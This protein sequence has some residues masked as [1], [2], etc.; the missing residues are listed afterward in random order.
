MAASGLNRVNASPQMRGHHGRR[1]SERENPRYGPV[2]RNRRVS[3]RLIVSVTR[4]CC[5]S[6]RFRQELV[7]R[8]PR[9][10]HEFLPAGGRSMNG[11]EVLPSDEN[12][13]ALQPDMSA[14]GPYDRAERAGRDRRRAHEDARPFR[15]THTR[16]GRGPSSSVV[17]DHLGSFGVL[18]GSEGRRP[19]S[20]VAERELLSTR[21]VRR[22]R[23]AHHGDGE[24]LRLRQSP[25]G[26]P[27]QSA[28][29]TA[30]S[31]GVQVTGRIKPD[32]PLAPVPDRTVNR[33]T[34]RGTHDESI[35]EEIYLRGWDRSIAEITQ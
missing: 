35:E 33:L 34:L 18:P 27:G 8:D 5:G 26:E 21:D 15:T 14:G 31:P 16:H 4:P 23:A 22:E 12:V 10:H 2:N 25:K 1:R 29:V 13:V 28:H 11:H 30:P 20:A 32:G 19:R 3:P 24:G 9:R 7:G 17:T 6:C